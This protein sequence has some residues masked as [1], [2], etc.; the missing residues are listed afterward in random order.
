[1][2]SFASLLNHP[3][4]SFLP[5]PD[6]IKVD[7]PA[8]GETL[9]F[10][11]TTRSD[12][13]KLLIQKAED[14]QKIWAAKTALERADVLWRW[15]FLMKENKEELARIMTMEQGKS[16]TEARGEID[17]AASF[18]RWFAEE[19]RR[20]DGD[21]LT[22]VKASQK[23]VVL[24]QPVGVTAAITPWNFPSAMIAR[25]AAP[26]LAV[27]CAMIVKPASFTPLSAYALAL[28]AYEAGVPQDLLPVVSGSA[29]E[30]SHEFATN[31]TVRKISFT[32]STE[33]GA[34]IFADSAADIK[35][36]S[37]ELGGNAPFIVFD[38][39]DLNK[40]VE[41]ALASK[42]RNSGQTCVC[43]NR[44]YAQS[45]IYDEFCRKLS[46]K[47]A[48]LKLGNGLDEGVN[49]GPLIEEKAVEK[50]E[51]HIADALSKGASCLT[52]GKR[53]ALGGTFFE[54][55][56]L[57]GVTAQMAVARE[58]TFGPLCPV[59]RFESE[60]EVIAAANDTEYGLAAYLFTADTARQWRV[61]EALEYG[62]VGI[63]TGLISNEVVPFGGVKRS[64]LGRE[65]SKYGADEY[66]EL[67]YLCIDV[68]E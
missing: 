24:K 66:L 13:L 35:K 43:T 64:G 10:V 59:F 56:V 44:V 29:S 54:P 14:A 67:K 36:L 15:Y 30:I 3:D 17:Y 6:S 51:Q 11:R 31:P 32:G 41:G 39:A 5:I 8:T 25:K 62:M 61:G 57:S 38:D 19:A 27:G 42:F 53:S 49:Q 46:E 50:V 16:L 52:G 45:G 37:L 22:S 28:L 47:V 68:A 7:N 12:D 23:L 63:N 2:N 18:V 58:E 48:A 33:V 9:A 65:G 55:T 20:I 4:I 26:A 60:A 1:M 40:A 34:K 21:V